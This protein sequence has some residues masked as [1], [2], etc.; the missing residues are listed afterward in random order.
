MAKDTFNIHKY[1]ADPV[2]DTVDIVY[3]EELEIYESK[4]VRPS[5]IL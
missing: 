4:F 1:K 5:F 3:N 2:S